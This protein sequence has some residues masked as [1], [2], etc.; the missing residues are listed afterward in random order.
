MYVPVCVRPWGSELVSQSQAKSVYA[1]QSVRLCGAGV[2]VCF[3]PQSRNL[4]CGLIP[5]LC[6]ATCQPH[7]LQC[8]QRGQ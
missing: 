8:P 2:C 5:I 4:M 3:G 6:L 7:L 1:L